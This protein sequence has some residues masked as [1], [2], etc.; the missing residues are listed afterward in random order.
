MNLITFNS[1]MEYLYRL[2]LYILFGILPSLSWL[3][4]Y[5]G[6]DL[7][8]EPKKTI[9]KIFFYG[10]I[11]TIPVFLLQVGLSAILD[12]LKSSGLFDGY[13]VIADILK[14]FIVIALT[15]E[16]LKYVVVKMAIL[17]NPEL[18]EPLDI[19]LYMVVSALGFAALENVLYL[20]SPIDHVAFADVIKVTVIITFIRFVGSTF[21]HTLCSA[22]LGYFLALSSLRSKKRFPL[23]IT[24]LLSATLLHG[25]YDFSIMVIDNP[26]N[27]T[28]PFFVIVVLAFFMLYDF[29]E[30]KKLKGI[31]KI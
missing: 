29:D 6:K 23:F 9:L 18:D 31:C 25:L 4:Y 8:P 15:E 28:I 19:M 14:W 20:F 16:L 11:V 2:P 17:G 26:L 1:F 13:P 30:V 27:L 5:L 3:A 7:H 24:G 22:L 10:V 21:L 12:H